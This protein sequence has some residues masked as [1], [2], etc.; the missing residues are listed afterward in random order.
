MIVQVG[1]Y[2]IVNPTQLGNSVIAD[3]SH[4]LVNPTNLPQVEI[5]AATP[6]PSVDDTPPAQQPTPSDHAAVVAIFTT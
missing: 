1:N 3:T 4:R 2:V 6:L 5:I